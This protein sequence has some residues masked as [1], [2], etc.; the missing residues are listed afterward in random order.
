MALTTESANRV[1][2]KTYATLRNSGVQMELKGFFLN[3]AANKGNIDLQLVNIDGNSM[4]SDGGATQ[5]VVC[6]GACTLYVIYLKKVG[7]VAN[8]FKLTDNAT[9]CTTNGGQDLSLRTTTAADEKLLTWPIGFTMVNG[10]TL[11]ENTTATGATE[12]L[13]ANQQSGFAIIGA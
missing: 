9:T 1:R 7:S 3:L 12:T 13:K 8:W 2:Q 6:N 10:I 5:Q 4:S 11:D